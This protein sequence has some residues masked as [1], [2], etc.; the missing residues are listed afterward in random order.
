MATT[1]D[2]GRISAIGWAAGYIGGLF[3]LG[4]CFLF[5]SWAQSHGH[6]P[7]EFVP[8]ILLYCA[9]F[10]ALAVSPTFIVLRERATPDPFASSINPISVGFGRLK[11]TVTHLRHYRDLF[12]FL[13]SLFLYSCGTTTVIHLAS[14]YAQHVLKFTASDLIAMILV[15]NVTAAIGAWIFGCMQDKI[16]SVRTLFIT[17]SIWT[18]AITGA[19]LAQSKLHLWIVANL[20]GIAMG[21]TGSVGRALVGQLAPSGRSGEF[22]GLWG[23]AVKL[24]TACGALTF[25]IITFLTHDNY[26]AALFSTVVFFILG[27]F[28]LRK[29]DENRGKEAAHTSADTEI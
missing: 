18:V 22:L 17:L 21:S 2:M 1:Q 26:R 6:G 8:V 16:G 27:M 4:A 5:V 15:V 10:F 23:V 29:V 7:T 12:N 13:I 24:A 28:M 25:G 9:A 11:T 20:V 19:C 14:V 3:S